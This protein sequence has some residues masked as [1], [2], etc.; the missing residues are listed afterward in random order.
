MVGLREH[1]KRCEQEIGYP[2]NALCENINKWIDAPWHQLKGR[3]RRYRHNATVTPF[4]ACLFHGHTV[5]QRKDHKTLIPA[6]EINFVI[7]KIVLYHLVLDGIID[8]NS[9]KN[10]TWDNAVKSLRTYTKKILLTTII[11]VVFSVVPILM[12]CYYLTLKVPYGSSLF[13]IIILVIIAFFIVAVGI[14]SFLSYSLHD[15]FRQCDVRVLDSIE[16]QEYA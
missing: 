11:V 7:A 4:E 6:A 5:Y 15:P 13:L 14:G 8:C 10:W 2:Y 3:H 1:I 16:T 9:F 12:Y